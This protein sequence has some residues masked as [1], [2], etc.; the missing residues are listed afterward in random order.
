MNRTYSPR[1]L[2]LCSDYEIP[3]FVYTEKFIGSFSRIP[4]LHHLSTS[5]RDHQHLFSLG[6]SVRKLHNHSL[7]FALVSHSECIIFILHRSMLFRQAFF[8]MNNFFCF[9]LEKKYFRNLETRPTHHP[10]LF[11]REARSNAR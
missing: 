9:L 10:P 8:F 3:L 2:H 6:R 7:L 11:A 4:P 5:I 1:L